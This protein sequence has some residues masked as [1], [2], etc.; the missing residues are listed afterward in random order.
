MHNTVV[1][2]I[3]ET[4]EKYDIPKTFIGI[5]L[6][7]LVVSAFLFLHS[8]DKLRLSYAQGLGKCSGACHKC[9]DGD[10]R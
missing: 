6:L 2:S 3:E 8:R 5:I 1:A 10:E 7:P 9:L 4:A